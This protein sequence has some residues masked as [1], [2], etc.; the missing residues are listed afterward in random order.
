MKECL[1]FAAPGNVTWLSG[2]APPAA[3]VVL[4]R[5]DQNLRICLRAFLLS[6]PFASGPV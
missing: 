3:F 4:L 6:L 2:K 1:S 5:I